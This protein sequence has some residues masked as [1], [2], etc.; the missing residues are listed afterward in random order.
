MLDRFISVPTFFF[1][2][3]AASLA[4]AEPK[5][6]L[7]HRGYGTSRPCPWNCKMA[8]LPADKCRDWRSGGTCYVED[9]TRPPRQ[10]NEPAAQSGVPPI[11]SNDRASLPA[12]VP[13]NQQATAARDNRFVSTSVP[14]ECRALEIDRIGRPTV[15]IYD[16]D[17][18]GGGFFS[19]R[20]HVE[21]ALEGVCLIEAGVFEEGKKVRD[22]PIQTTREFRRFDFDVRADASNYPEIRVYD[23]NGQRDVYRLT[24][25]R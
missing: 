1:I 10:G 25:E 7:G 11:P 19:D 3:L 8:G 5:S 17:R 4:Y 13:Q 14:D 21:G 24:P 18:S 12:V 6:Y 9:F 22:I 15:E 20:Y 2:L 16:I 23:V